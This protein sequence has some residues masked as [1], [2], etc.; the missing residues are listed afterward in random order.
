[1]RTDKS[2]LQ[3][4][5][6]TCEQAEVPRS[7]CSALLWWAL[8]MLRVA[9]KGIYCIFYP[10]PHCIACSRVNKLVLLGAGVK[11][12]LKHHPQKT[13]GLNTVGEV[14]WQLVLGAWGEAQGSWNAAVCSGHVCWAPGDE[15]GKVSE[16]A[17]LSMDPVTVLAY[18]GTWVTWYQ[19]GLEVKSYPDCL[20]LMPIMPIMDA[21]VVLFVQWKH[22]KARGGHTQGMPSRE[23]ISSIT[24][25]YQIS[26]KRIPNT[27]APLRSRREMKGMLITTLWNWVCGRGP[28]F[29]AH[30]ETQAEK[31]PLKIIYLCYRQGVFPFA[32]AD[33]DRRTAI[34]LRF[35]Q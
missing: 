33:F 11:G 27:L 5:R 4:S 30:I 26:R 19:C 17:G 6:N 15:R 32:A 16:A 25:M 29:W 9:E 3:S 12:A 28:I 20:F 21:F 10:F 1:M 24:N 8:W 7:F 35:S 22:E 23:G 2:A 31:T 13:N 18:K 34:I 14:W